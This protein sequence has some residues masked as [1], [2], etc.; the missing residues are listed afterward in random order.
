MATTID[1]QVAPDTAAASKRFVKL[2]KR[3]LD[4]AHPLS[5]ELAQKP[6][7]LTV[8][9]C[10]GA[11]RIVLGAFMNDEIDEVLR[12]AMQARV[13]SPGGRTSPAMIEAFK[14]LMPADSEEP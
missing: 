7:Q 5:I 12:V 9:G 8:I 13:Q 1:P 11:H 3:L 10:F 2:F 14:A 6:G 4:F